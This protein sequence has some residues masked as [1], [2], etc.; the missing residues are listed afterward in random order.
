MPWCLRPQRAARRRG[1]LRPRRAA[2]QAVAPHGQAAAQ[3]AGKL[4]LRPALRE[5]RG[6]PLRPAPERRRWRPRARLRGRRLRRDVVPQGLAAQARLVPFPTMGKGIFP[7]RHGTRGTTRFPL[8]TRRR[9]VGRFWTQQS[10][11]PAWSRSASPRRRKTLVL[12]WARKPGCHVVV[13]DSLPRMWPLPA[14]DGGRGQKT[15]RATATPVA[16]GRRLLVC[17]AQ[18]KDC[19]SA[20][21][22]ASI[23]RSLY[24]EM[25]TAQ[26]LSRFTNAQPVRRKF[27][28]RMAMFGWT[29]SAVDSSG[30]S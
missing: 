5:V 27:P 7:S 12:L 23:S 25:V 6:K 15:G 11:I 30:T 20:G 24:S 21:V 4:R 1:P 8:G 14:S 22:I 26:P 3:P 10:A 29:T 13:A 16:R 19:C 2:P 17:V 9:A 28:V 18:S